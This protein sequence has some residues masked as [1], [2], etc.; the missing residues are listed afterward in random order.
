MKMPTKGL[1]R[2]Y[3]KLMARSCHGS[4]E[5]T[6]SELA[7]GHRR[8]SDADESRLQQMEKDNA[9]DHARY[10]LKQMKQKAKPRTEKQTQDMIQTIKDNQRARQGGWVP[11]AQQKDPGY[12]D[13][14][15]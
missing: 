12:L 7:E 6:D 11:G 5:F 9:D 13:N 4:G 14:D 2:S 1:S 3:R 10:R 15:R 8:Q